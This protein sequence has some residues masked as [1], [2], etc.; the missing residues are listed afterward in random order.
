[1]SHKEDRLLLM[2]SVSG[3]SQSVWGVS[4]RTRSEALDRKSIPKAPFFFY[5]SV[6][7]HTIMVENWILWFLPAQFGNFIL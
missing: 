4:K 5:Y 3:R 1:V 7:D 6:Y 2:C